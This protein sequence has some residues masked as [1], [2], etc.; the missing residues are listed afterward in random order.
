M[1]SKSEHTYHI[2]APE[3]KV[4]FVKKVLYGSG[5]FADMTFQ[6]T[7]IAFALPIFNM[8][9]GFS[10][11]VIGLVLGITRIWD[12]FTDPL[13]GSISDNAR[14]RFGRR[15]PFIGIGAILSAIFF[16]TI[17][18]VPKGINDT[19]FFVYFL[20]T[21]LLFYTSFTVFSV[22]LYAM[23]YEM[24]SDYHER[25]KMM[26]VR[27]FSNS[28]NG[29]ILFPWFLWF[30][31]RSIWSD[32]TQGVRMV[33]LGIGLLMMVLALIPALTLKEKKKTYVEK[34]ERVSVL[35][36]LK[37]TFGCKPYVYLIIAFFAALCSYNTIATTYAYPL[38]YYV[39][40]GDAELNSIWFGRI[41][42][43]HHVATLIALVPINILA[44]RFSKRSVGLLGPLFIIIG[45][46][47]NFFCYV[48]DMPWLVLIPRGFAALGLATLFVLVPSMI[49]D[50]VDFDEQQ[51]GTRREGMF[52]AVHF[53]VIKLALAIGLVA[54][55][56]IVEA[57]G[58]NVDFGINQPEGAL[59]K[60][61]SLLGLLPTI[62]AF[63]ALYFISRY[64][65][66]EKTMYEI[67]LG[68]EKRRGVS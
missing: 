50:V 51:T 6:W 48:P 36:S 22:P 60:I 16:I 57:T 21:S 12:G 5:C 56:F 40:A 65:L 25:T 19:Q 34:Q 20:I 37:F 67:R 15:R 9:L 42:A 32:S 64:P 18:F 55:G 41:E 58:F 52:G 24:S 38:R 17:W 59:D 29:I 3:D 33:G 46:L 35:K 47:A 53:W 13:M 62:G 39:C 2:T 61:I 54:T 8:E 45:S 4:P 7:L 11:I 30:I 23:G 10:P 27:I 31:Q 66:T 43:F 68:L 49:A 14:T 28:F 1:T 63:V 44:K 26:G